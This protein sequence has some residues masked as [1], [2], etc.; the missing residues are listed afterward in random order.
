LIPQEIIYMTPLFYKPWW[1]HKHTVYGTTCWWDRR[2]L[3]P[4]I[5]YF[6]SSIRAPWWNTLPHNIINNYYHK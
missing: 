5:P 2:V 4:F 3:G 1:C 6:I